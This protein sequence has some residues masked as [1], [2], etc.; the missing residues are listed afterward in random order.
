MSPCVLSSGGSIGSSRSADRVVEDKYR[1]PGSL[2]E[3]FQCS[4]TL[5]CVFFC[6]LVIC[7]EQDFLDFWSKWTHW[8]K[9]FE[10]LY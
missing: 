4:S 8:H 10:F 9:P 5:S 3:E 6:D 7:V 1:F 2:G